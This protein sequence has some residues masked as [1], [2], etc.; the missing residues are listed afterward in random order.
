M[1]DLQGRLSEYLEAARDLGF[2][3]GNR[4][5]EQRGLAAKL[6]THRLKSVIK[7]WKRRLEAASGALD[8][9]AGPWTAFAGL[10]KDQFAARS[11]EVVRKL[12][13]PKDARAPA[14]P[15]HPLVVL[16]VL[17]SP[18]ATMDEVIARYKRLF[19]ELEAHWR[20][21]QAKSPGSRALPEPEWES[22]RQALYGPGGSFHVS[23]EQMREYLDQRQSGQLNRLNGA[24]IDLE[25]THPGA[26]ARAMVM[27]DAVRPVE[28]HIFIRGN[29]NRRGAA[30]PRRFP[31]V[32]AG[33]DRHPFQKG[34]GRLELARAITDPKNPLTARVIVNRAWLWH[35]GKG[36]VSTPSD[37]GM[38]SDP[39]SHPGLLDYLASEFMASG[40]SLKTLHRRIMLSSTYQQRERPARRRIGARS[41]EPAA[42]AVQSTAAGF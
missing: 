38:R 5:L 14:P 8:P 9:V 11:P 1:G 42:V 19:S 17:G 24:L 22:L 25:S 29:R 3:R 16:S 2:D 27:Y 35:F 40:W 10:P 31:R 39:P 33:P 7:M 13:G 21:H 12:T 6:N 30:V 23:T 28:P 36:L 20:E 18:P 26:P 41:R 37:F 4:K 32:L 15:F 34:S